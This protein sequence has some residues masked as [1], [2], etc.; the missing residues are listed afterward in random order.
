MVI[1]ENLCINLELLQN[2]NEPTFYRLECLYVGQ[3]FMEYLQTLGLHFLCCIEKPKR[4]GIILTR[5]EMLFILTYDFL[6]S[7]AEGQLSFR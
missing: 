5:V 7:N 6:I 2:H 4:N 1:A 3:G